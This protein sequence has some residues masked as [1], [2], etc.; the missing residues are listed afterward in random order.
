MGQN[1]V[2]RILLFLQ[3]ETCQS[4][5]KRQST[6]GII[7]K[8]PQD[9]HQ[10][11]ESANN[12]VNGELFSY[13]LLSSLQTKFQL[14]QS[15]WFYTFNGIK[16][17]DVNFIYKYV[18]SYVLYQYLITISIYSYFII[19]ID[20]FRHLNIQRF[21]HTQLFSYFMYV[22]SYIATVAVSQNLKFACL[23]LDLAEQMVQLSNFANQFVPQRLDS[24][25]VATRKHMYRDIRMQLLSHCYQ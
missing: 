18:Y 5:T 19:L 10:V 11:S 6:G 20:V 14:L 17:R 22:V 16:Y 4:S 25:L 3:R 12:Q 15:Q 24:N 23:G 9:S 21:P 2:Q 13:Q 8:N 7:S 1:S